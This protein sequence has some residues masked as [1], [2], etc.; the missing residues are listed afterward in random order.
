MGATMKTT[1]NAD[2]HTGS[3]AFTASVQWMYVVKSASAPYPKF[4]TPDVL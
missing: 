2:N 3:P 1:I 4:R